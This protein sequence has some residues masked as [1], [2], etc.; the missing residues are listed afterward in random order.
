MTTDRIPICRK[1]LRVVA[2]TQPAFSSWCSATSGHERLEHKAGK[3]ATIHKL[4]NSGFGL[5]IAEEQSSDVVGRRR[6]GPGWLTVACEIEESS[7]H[8]PENL[9]R[10]FTEGADYVFVLC[11]HA[12]LFRSVVRQIAKTAN[13]VPLDRVICMTLGQF[14]ESDLTACLIELEVKNHKINHHESTSK[15]SKSTS[16]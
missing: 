13:L 9:I 8:V 6:W 12:R 7:R 5:V 11:P 15:S 2:S 16:D 3:L 1:D 4:A 10:N 14:L